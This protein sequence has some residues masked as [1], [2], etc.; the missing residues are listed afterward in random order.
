MYAE[1]ESFGQAELLDCKVNYEQVLTE[2]LLKLCGV[3]YVFNALVETT[4]ELGGDGLCGYL[5]L[6]Q[7]AQDEEYLNGSLRCINLI[8]GYLGDKVVGTF[9]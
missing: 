6:C 7:R 9:L 1:L 3:A 5:F 2:L 4:G 8:H